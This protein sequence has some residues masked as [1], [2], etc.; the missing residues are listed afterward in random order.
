MN[1]FTNEGIIIVYIIHSYI[2]IW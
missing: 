1:A 2:S